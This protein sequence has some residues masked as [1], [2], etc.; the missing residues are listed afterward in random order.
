[1]RFHPGRTL[2][3]KLQEMGISAEEFATL[4]SLPVAAVRS[5]INGSSRVTSA[6]A[7]AFESVT[8]IPA[9]MWLT[10]QRKHDQFT[11]AVEFH[12]G[13]TLAEK[14]QEMGISAE[15]FAAMTSLPVA[16][17]RSVISGECSV[18]ADMAAAFESVTK[19]PAHFWLNLQKGYDEYVARK[20]RERSPMTAELLR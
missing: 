16:A 13:V 3:E 19:I 1:M 2:A 7:T 4:A 9:R 11:L 6:M 14:L 8:K 18:T 20:K 10:K 17:V 15:E 5:V 12:P